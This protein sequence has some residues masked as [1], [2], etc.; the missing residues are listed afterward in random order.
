MWAKIAT[1]L[2]VFVLKRAS[3]SVTDRNKLVIHLLDKLGALPF[4]DI[5]TV[6]EQGS[7]LVSG[8]TVTMEQARVLRDSARGALDSQA[9]RII[10]EQVLFQA[11]TLGTHK[12]EDEKQMFFARAAIW[13]GQREDEFLRLLAGSDEE[14]IN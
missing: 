2:A 4:R 14:I 6:D 7:L 9:F 5:I 12:A 3:L 13:W 1:N 11:V 8:R 10:R